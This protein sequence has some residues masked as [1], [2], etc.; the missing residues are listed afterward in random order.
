MHKL[1]SSPC[2]LWRFCATSE[3][4][5]QSKTKLVYIYIYVYITVIFSVIHMVGAKGDVK[6][7]TIAEASRWLGYSPDLSGPQY[8]NESQRSSICFPSVLRWGAVQWGCQGKAL[9]LQEGRIS[10]AIWAFSQQDGPC[11]YL[12][13]ISLYSFTC[14]RYL[15]D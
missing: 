7:P 8:P 5:R 10:P 11:T 6:A 12:K 3:R 1:G 2:R 4:P 9:D 14:P 13:S 15:H